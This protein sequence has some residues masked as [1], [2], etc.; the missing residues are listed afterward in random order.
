MPTEVYL[1]YPSQYIVPFHYAHPVTGK[2]YVATRT[3]QNAE[4]IKAQ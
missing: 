2:P 3:D 4:R 1:T